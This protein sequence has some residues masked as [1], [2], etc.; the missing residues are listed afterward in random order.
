MRM[1]NFRQR[2]ARDRRM[3]P[4][5]EARLRRPRGGSRAAKSRSSLRQQNHH[6]LPPNMSNIGWRINI[7]VRRRNRPHW[8]EPSEASRASLVEP[9]LHCGPDEAR[10]RPHVPMTRVR[11]T[12]SRFASKNSVLDFQL[13]TCLFCSLSTWRCSVL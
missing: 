9:A 5:P 3:W 2:P 4:P 12:A 13:P 7:S 11:G 8:Q 10:W 1:S 6:R